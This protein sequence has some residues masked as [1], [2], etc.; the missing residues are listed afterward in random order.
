MRVI[1]IC[2]DAYGD[3]EDLVIK[4]DEQVEDACKLIK[5]ANENWLKDEDVALEDEVDLYT[6]IDTLLTKANIIYKWC[7][8]PDEVII[9]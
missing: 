3:C 8:A 5:Q 1:R 2:V 7:T 6:Y 9:L 4:Y